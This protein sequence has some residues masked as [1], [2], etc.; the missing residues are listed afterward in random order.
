MIINKPIS[1]LNPQWNK[2]VVPLRLPW[3]HNCMGLE[4]PTTDIHFEK[5]NYPRLSDASLPWYRSRGSERYLTN[6]DSIKQI[7]P[8]NPGYV[9][10]HTH[11]YIYTRFWTNIDL[12][13]IGIH[14]FCPFYAD[15][16]MWISISHVQ[17]RSILE[18]RACFLSLILKPKSLQIFHLTVFYLHF[19]WLGNQV[20]WRNPKWLRLLTWRY[21]GSL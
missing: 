12:T 1:V 5:W 10:T 13:A 6:I 17:N 8:I 16:N 11:I 15:H 9:Y 21:L 3:A 4:C 2:F 20:T 14:M 7:S 19:K 18:T